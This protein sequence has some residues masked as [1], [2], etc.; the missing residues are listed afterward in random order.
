MQEFIKQNALSIEKSVAGRR[1]IRFEKTTAAAEILPPE[2]LRQNA[3]RL[4][5]MSEL[6]TVRHFTN[7][8][9]Q[10]YCL[11]SHFI[12]WALAR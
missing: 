6:D 9:R 1:G 2:Y 4:P 8:S 11:D 7:L 10:N 12:L 3:P 5:E